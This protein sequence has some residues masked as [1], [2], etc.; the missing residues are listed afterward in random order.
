MISIGLTGSIAMGKSEVL[1]ILH[2]AGCAI[3][4]ADA[5]VHRFYCEPAAVEAVARLASPAVEDGRIDRA[6]LSELAIA[7]KSLLP[8]LESLVATELERRR[9]HF[10]AE[11]ERKGTAI[12]VFDIPLLFEKNLDQRMDATIVVSA[13]KELQ[14]KRALERPGM[15]REKLAMILARQMPD[16]LKRRKAHYIIENSG[17]LSALAAKTRQVLADIRRKHTI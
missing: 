11:T 9:Q 1:E 13:P 4:D 5:E 3:F 16:A 2:E 10:I 17:S 12:A 7:D 14:E 6:K 15:T 8:A